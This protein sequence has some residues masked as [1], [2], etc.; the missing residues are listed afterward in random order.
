MNLYVGN[1]SRQT[2]EDEIQEA[3]APFGRIQSIT[4]VKEKFSGESRGFGFVDMP[5]TTEALAAIAGLAGQELHGRSL[6][7]NEARSRNDNR[8]N[9]RDSGGRRSW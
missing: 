4:I 7:V 3:F 1:L 9:S 8:R 6:V 5:N 2:T